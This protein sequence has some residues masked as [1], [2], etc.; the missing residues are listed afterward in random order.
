MPWT[1]PCRGGR[2]KGGVARRWGFWGGAGDG[3]GGGGSPGRAPRG[4]GG[5]G[6]WGTLPNCSATVSRTDGSAA[7]V[8]RRN[9]DFKPRHLPLSRRCDLAGSTLSQSP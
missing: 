4:T 9:A 3:G 8:A 5:E 1:I 7:H 2:V 6:R